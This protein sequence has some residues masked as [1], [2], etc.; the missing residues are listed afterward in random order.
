MRTLGLTKEFQ[1]LKGLGSWRTLTGFQIFLLYTQG[2]HSSNP[3]LKLANAF[4]VEIDA[5][6]RLVLQY[7]LKLANAFGV[8]FG[9]EVCRRAPAENEEEDNGK[10]CDVHQQEEHGVKGADDDVKD[11]PGAEEPAG[12][13]AAVQHEDAG[14]DLQ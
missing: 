9:V 5:R 7:Q 12:P 2:S 14:N 13:V 11:D 8:I 10:D 6:A 1:T 4:G 3:G